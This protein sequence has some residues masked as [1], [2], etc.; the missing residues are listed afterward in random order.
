MSGHSAQVEALS[1]KAML[2]SEYQRHIELVRLLPISKLR[3]QEDSRRYLCLRFAGFLEQ[4]V[5]LTI[6]QHLRNTTSGPALEFGRS[7]FSQAPNLNPKALI[8]V[9]TRF[10]P[11]DAEKVDSFLTKTR[12]DVLADLI[13]VRNPIAHGVLVG[14]A[15]L[16]PARYVTLCDDFHQWCFD[17]Y[18]SK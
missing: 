15:K 14:G 13:S 7:F 2:D 4:M 10:G 12:T 11:S 18:L 8:A 1:L 9:F 6:H 5:F 17:E 3:L 16:D